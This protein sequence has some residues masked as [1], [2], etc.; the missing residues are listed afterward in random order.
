MAGFHSVM[1]SPR[2]NAQIASAV[3]VTSDAASA[4]L[5]A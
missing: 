3:D 5:R 2:S 4:W 1:R